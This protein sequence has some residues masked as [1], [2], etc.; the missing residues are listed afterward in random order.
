MTCLTIS[1]AVVD[2]AIDEQVD[3]IVTHHPLPFKALQRITTDTVA[4][5]DAVAF[6]RCRH[7]HLHAHTAFDSARE[8][9][10]QMWADTVGLAACAPCWNRPTIWNWVPV[11]LV[12]L[13]KPSTLPAPD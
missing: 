3:L 8:G 4:G 12:T 5:S 11:E 2:E 10:N 13:P 9:I 1:P 7:R 6:D